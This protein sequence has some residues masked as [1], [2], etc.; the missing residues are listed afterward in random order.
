[1]KVRSAPL[2]DV[3]QELQATLRDGGWLGRTLLRLFE[4]T[5][6]AHRGALLLALRHRLGQCSSVPTFP[7]LGFEP[8]NLRPNELGETWGRRPSG[9]DGFATGSNDAERRA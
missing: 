5:Y 3:H 8:F 2:D 6:R 9:V 7:A 4:A 1:M